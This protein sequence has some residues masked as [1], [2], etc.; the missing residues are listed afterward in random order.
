L[1]TQLSF[2][3]GELLT[4]ISK[5]NDHWWRAKNA[6]GVEGDVPFNFVKEISTTEETKGTT[7]SS[8]TSPVASSS[9]SS[10]E[11]KV[12]AVYTFEATLDTQLPFVKGE[13]LTIISKDSSEWWRARNAAGREGDIPHNFVGPISGEEKVEGLYDFPGELETQLPFAKGE[14]LVIIS[15]DSDQWWRAR[16]AAGKEGDIPFNFVGPTAVVVATT[17]ALAIRCEALFDF[18]T[19]L[20]T[21]LPFTKGDILTVIAKD[22]DHWW[23]AKNASGREG[24]IPFNFVKELSATGAASSS[25]SGIRVEALYPFEAT[26]D[27]QLS[28]TAVR[29]LDLP[30]CFL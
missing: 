11:E 18:A 13:I 25:S 14:I 24:D 9:S 12:E 28:F 16:N 7:A 2:K 20:D 22:S 21:Q 26:L 17:D 4:I 19:E 27:S 8:A 5:D 1:E 15:K 23:R 6:A 3:A 30:L 10:N 29:V